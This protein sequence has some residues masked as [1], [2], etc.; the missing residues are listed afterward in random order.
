MW[1]GSGDPAAGEWQKFKEGWGG[2]GGARVNMVP[3]VPLGVHVKT[4]CKV[5]GWNCQIKAA[6]LAARKTIL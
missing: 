2:G 3:K 6:Q 1:E 5:N 4:N